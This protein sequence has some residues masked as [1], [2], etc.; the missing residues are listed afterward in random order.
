MMLRTKPDLYDVCK[1]VKGWQTYVH[2]V[3]Q[4]YSPLCKG[5]A[6]KMSQAEVV[7]VAR[8]LGATPAQVL[9]RWS[10]QRGFVPLPK[11]ADPGRMTENADVYGFELSTEQMRVL[12]SLD[13][14]FVT[15]WDPSE[16]SPV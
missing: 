10:I 14:N 4:A 11:T 6:S 7:E 12:D 15:A 2:A 16:D 13:V 8:Q 9:L 1:I 5:S 3:I